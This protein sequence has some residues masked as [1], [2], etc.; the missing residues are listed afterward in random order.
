MVPDTD[1]HARRGSTPISLLDLPWLLMDTARHPTHVAG[2]IICAGT[3]A[4]STG[5]VDDLVRDMARFTAPTDPLNRQVGTGWQGFWPRWESVHDVEIEKHVHRWTLPIPGGQQQL[6]GLVSDLHST[7]LDRSRPLWE[8]HVVDGLAGNR[9][10]IYAK[11]HHSLVDGVGAIRVLQSAFST[12]SSTRDMPPVW[13]YRAPTKKAGRPRRNARSRARDLF[14]ATCA[15]A[16]NT[17]A[18]AQIRPYSAPRSVLNT[19]ISAQRTIMTLSLDLGRLRR[20]ADAIGG[21]INDAYVAVCTTALRRFLLDIDQ[22]PHRPLTATLPVS[23]RPTDG[24]DLGNAITFAFASLATDVAGARE[25]TMRVMQSIAQAR[26]RLSPLRKDV[27]DAYTVLTMAPFIVCQM[28]GLGAKGPPMFNLAISN[29][30]GPDETLYYNG[31]AVLAIYPVSLLETGQALNITAVSYAGRLNV[32][33]TACAA[34]LPGV[35]NLPS[36]CSDALDELEREF[37]TNDRSE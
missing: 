10:A 12:D 24:D 29:I 8:V 32:T 1:P 4:A 26:A 15:V 23:V 9:F 35:P 7:R 33:I 18:G 3:A 20:L 25:R 31:S 21:T 11:F 34:R 28:V 27:V 17:F 16:A 30:R 2:L 13:A 19:A 5:F 14:S 36:H 37:T 6:E 22:L